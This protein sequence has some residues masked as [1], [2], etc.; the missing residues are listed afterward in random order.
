MIVVKLVVVVVV[1][2][3]VEY[4]E[5]AL[6]LVEEMHTTSLLVKHM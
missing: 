2:A 3:V 4:R 5:E 6:N 1:Q